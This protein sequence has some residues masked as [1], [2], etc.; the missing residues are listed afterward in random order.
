MR[1]KRILGHYVFR[2][3]F[4]KFNEHYSFIVKH[5]TVS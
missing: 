5:E 2:E 1:A 4:A 3:K